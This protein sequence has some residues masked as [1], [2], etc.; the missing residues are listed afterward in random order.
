[1]AELGGVSLIADTS[2]DCSRVAYQ[3]RPKAPIPTGCRSV[4][5]SL[6]ISTVESRHLSEREVLPAGDLERRAEDLG[7]HELCHG[8]RV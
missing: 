3:T 8:G 1:M 7:T 5:L 6:L 2:D 4:Y